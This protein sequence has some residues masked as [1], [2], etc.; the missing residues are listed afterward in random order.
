MTATAELIEVATAVLAALALAVSML[1]FRQALRGYRDACA[2]RR[3][4]AVLTLA[5][6][7]V[8]NEAFRIVVSAGVVYSG[9]VQATSPAPATVTGNR[10][11]FQVIW[12]LIAFICLAQSV[13]NE[14]DTNRTIDIIERERAAGWPE[15]STPHG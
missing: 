10:P 15:R 9:F 4:T 1:L 11:I 7:R 8:R 13:L 12:L 6:M 2:D 5:W 14:R 3:C